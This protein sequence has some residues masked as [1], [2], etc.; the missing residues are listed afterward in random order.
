MLLRNYGQK[1][2]YKHLILG[3][4][5]RL[6]NLQA[7]ILRVKLKKLNRWN[8]KRLSHALL[9][10]K[11]LE[12]TPVITPKIFDAYKHVFH[13]YV[14]RV[15]QRDKLSKYLLSKGISTIMHYPIPIHLQPAYKDLGFKK[16]VFPITEKVADEVLSLPM[17]PELTDEE[18]KYICDQIK[19]FYRA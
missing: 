15:K 13:L 11:H 17:F 14:I 19:S 1:E 2:K 8:E 12:N 18:I 16:G 10:N 4:N 3:D 5:S 7:A 9:Y 6:D